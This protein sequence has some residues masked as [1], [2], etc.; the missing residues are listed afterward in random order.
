MSDANQNAAKL[1][2][3]GHETVNQS[4]LPIRSSLNA[5]QSIFEV[6]DLNEREQTAIERIL[7]DGFQAGVVGEESVQVDIDEVKRITKELKAIKRQELVLIGERISRAKAVFRKYKDRSFRDWLALTFGT[8]KTGYNYL[9]FYDL[10]SIIPDDLKNRFK[11]MPAKAA[12]ILASKKAPLDRKIGIVKDHAQETAQNLITL[13]RSISEEMEA[14]PKPR[15][16]DPAK[17]RILDM[18]QKTLFDLAQRKGQFEGWEK[19]RIR[20]MAQALAQIAD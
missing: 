17:R 3:R 12:Y 7:I 15:L 20:H 13:I 10:Y 5:F 9:A 4:P 16:R 1:F 6:Q 14:P 11:A 8:Y 19:E 2:Q 18:L